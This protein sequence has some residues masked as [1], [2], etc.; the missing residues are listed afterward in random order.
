MNK[1][2]IEDKS[3]IARLD[4]MFEKKEGRLT[5][6]YPAEI[7]AVIDEQRQMINEYWRQYDNVKAYGGNTV[8]L[9]NDITRKEKFIQTVEWYS[10]GWS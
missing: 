2:Y 3:E 7:Q 1:H 4:A 6:I 10:N 8:P 5:F 9:L